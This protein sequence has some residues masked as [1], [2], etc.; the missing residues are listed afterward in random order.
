MI[1]FAKPVLTVKPSALLSKLKTFGTQ[2]HIVSF[3]RSQCL[4]TVGLHAV[5]AFGYQL[6]VW[7]VEQTVWKLEGILPLKQ[8]D[9][10]YREGERTKGLKKSAF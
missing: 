6:G 3:R 7:A 4:H 5:L 10:I 2:N 8:F 9:P 1:K